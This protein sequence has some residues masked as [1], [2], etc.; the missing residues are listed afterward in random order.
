MTK[1]IFDGADLS[2]DEKTIHGPHARCLQ[3]R[4]ARR[5]IPQGSEHGADLD[6][7]CF[8]RGADLTGAILRGSELAAADFTDANVSGADFDGAD[9]NSARIG[10][11]KNAEAAK[12]L[13]KAKNIEK[14][15][16]R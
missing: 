16:R 6:G 13:D 10:Q 12:N 4:Q 11:M 14:A 1:A 15:V 5:R 7:I 3:G 9:L 2:A 8:S